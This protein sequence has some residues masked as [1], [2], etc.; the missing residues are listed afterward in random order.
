MSNKALA[1]LKVVEY[2]SFVAAPLA[3]KLLADMGA[4]V[5]KIEAPNGGDEA[6]R[7]GP[8][9]GDQPHPE[10]SGLYLYLNTSKKGVTLDLR[11]STGAAMFKRL[12]EAADVFIENTPAG[13]MQS[14][15]LGYEAL[16]EVNPKLVMTS[17]TPFGQTGPYKNF[18]SH[19]LTTFHA[20]GEGFTMPGGI[21]WLLF[22]DRQPIKVGGFFGEYNTGVDATIGTLG[23]L[24]GAMETGKGTYVD[25]SQQEVLLG[26]LRNDVLKFNEG[27]IE[28]RATRIYPVAGLMQCKDGFIQIMPLEAHMWYGLLELM[29]NPSWAENPKELYRYY[30]KRGFGGFD[31]VRDDK[32]NEM[33][34]HLDEWALQHTKE[35]IFHG[36]QKKGCAAGPVYDMKELYESEVLK[37]RQYFVDVAHPVAGTY[38]YPGAFAK[39]SGTPWGISSPAPT[40]GQ[41]NE[42]V[43]CGRLG[44]SKEELVLLRQGGV[45]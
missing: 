16:R 23:A 41:H 40:L 2:G 37:E 5:I 43:Y 8:F 21:G 22:P 32:C 1:G 36:A 27:F 28:R 24:W 29:G 15:G 14:W 26:L 6:R 17:V 20:G 25:V 19:Y 30:I 7:M 10:K 42:E 45:I 31:K 33:Q 44:Y 3:G 39:F 18:K 13:T 11:N 34:F 9:P 35:E 38:T 4:E 12:I